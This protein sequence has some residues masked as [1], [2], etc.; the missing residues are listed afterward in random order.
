LER[1]FGLGQ[2][3]QCIGLENFV[4]NAGTQTLRSGI[5]VA[6]LEPLR[7]IF[8]E[9]DLDLS[10]E[11]QSLV[12]ETSYLGYANNSAR[13]T[14]RL[15]EIL[16]IYNFVFESGRGLVCRFYSKADLQSRGFIGQQVC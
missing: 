11:T 9:A 8:L 7:N 16:Q 2:E 4:R 14:L 12:S 3:N 1:K 10:A 15:T 5:S 13:A 6:V